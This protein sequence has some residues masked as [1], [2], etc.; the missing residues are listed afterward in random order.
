MTGRCCKTCRHIAP[1]TG[2]GVSHYVQCLYPISAPPLPTNSMQRSILAAAIA[3]AMRE[4]SN[5]TTIAHLDGTM[6]GAEGVVAGANCPV[7]QA[8]ADEASR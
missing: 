6:R 5:W 4:P 3:E 7:W 1:A 8:C 2:K